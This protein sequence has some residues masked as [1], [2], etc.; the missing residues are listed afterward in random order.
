[1]HDIGSRDA[2][3]K[4]PLDALSQSHQSMHNRHAFTSPLATHRH[5]VILQIGPDSLVDNLTLDL[6]RRQHIWVANSRELEDLGGLESTA[7]H[8]DLPRDFDQVINSSMT[9]IDPSSLV[10]LK[11]DRRNGGLT[12]HMK[13]RAL[14]IRL[15]IPPRRITPPAP[16]RTRAGH[17][18]Q[19]IEETDMIATP[20]IRRLPIEPRHLI[21]SPD[22]I[23]LKRDNSIIEARADGARGAMV[24]ADEGHGGA[25]DDGRVDGL[26]RLVLAHV[27]VHGAAAPARVGRDGRPVV[28]VLARAPHVHH[29]VDRAGAAEDFAAREVVAFILVFGLVSQ[30]Q[31]QCRRYRALTLDRP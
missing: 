1:M 16:I 27:G 20:R 7:G 31:L 17:R 29:V 8:H 30:R 25:I 21:T 9:K 11:L 4:L 2:G 14:R 3:L 10:P 23:V 6:R 13:I 5:T 22:D 19:R 15:E 12:Q 18:A 24:V 28:V 26:Q